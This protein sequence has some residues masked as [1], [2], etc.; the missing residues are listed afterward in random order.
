MQ[1]IAIQCSLMQSLYDAND[2]YYGD[3]TLRQ[4]VL[5]KRR[6]IEK[7]I[8]NKSL[9]GYY[10]TL[11]EKRDAFCI[12]REQ[13]SG[14][15]RRKLNGQPICRLYVFSHFFRIV[16]Y[17]SKICIHPL[18]RLL[19]NFS[20]L[21]ESP[22]SLTAPLDDENK[23]RLF[24]TVP[25]SVYTFEDVPALWKI[26]YRQQRK[27]LAEDISLDSMLVILLQTIYQQHFFGKD[28]V[29]QF[30]Q[31]VWDVFEKLFCARYPIKNIE[32][33]ADK[34]RQLLLHY[35]S[36]KNQNKTACS[37]E[38]IEQ[39]KQSLIKKQRIVYTNLNAIVF[40]SANFQQRLLCLKNI[41]DPAPSR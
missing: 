6:A 9:F 3:C 21:E 29:G 17:S 32:F 4:Y 27:Q 39:I 28:V 2:L 1:G 36:V 19:N 38:S 13:H 25:E 11:N 16:G 22:F 12:E 34:V 37:N 7:R 23:K 35:R 20:L 18:F 10:V 30:E 5:E 26:S 41:S 40:N 24:S 31:L 14:F 8:I 15:W 33:L